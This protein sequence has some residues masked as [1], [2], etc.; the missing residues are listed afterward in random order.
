MREQTH[1]PN[2]NRAHA[3]VAP[4]SVQN[5]TFVFLGFGV[6]QTERPVYRPTGVGEHPTQRTRRFRGILAQPPS[7]RRARIAG[8]RGCSRRGT[9]THLTI[10]SLDSRG[11]VPDA[12]ALSASR[13]S[14][15]ATVT[16]PAERSGKSDSLC[17]P[18]A[19][20]VVRVDDTCVRS[21]RNSARRCK[22]MVLHDSYGRDARHEAR[23][24][25]EHV[26]VKSLNRARHPPVSGGRIRLF[27]LK[28]LIHPPVLGG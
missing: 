17:P 9:L 7:H 26:L 12:P 8:L 18:D 23:R 16:R 20:R 25:T 11:R 2:V 13:S 6:V 27:C 10:H 22:M 5:Q 19:H 1:S 21:R 3:C 24:A 15:H 14:S 4:P 28:S